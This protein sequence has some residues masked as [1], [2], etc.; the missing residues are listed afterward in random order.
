MNYFDTIDQD[1]ATREQ[2]TNSRH[3]S[4]VFSSQ[5]RQTLATQLSEGPELDVSRAYYK[6]S[7]QQ[8]LWVDEVVQQARE[9]RASKARS[10]NIKRK[11]RLFSRSADLDDPQLVDSPIFRFALQ[12]ALVGSVA[13]YL[14]FVPILTTVDFWWNPNSNLFDPKGEPELLTQLCHRDWADNTLVK[15]F[16]HC[17]PI[18]QEQGAI[19]LLSPESSRE[20]ADKFGYR[21]A[22]RLNTAG[23]LAETNG[24]YLSDQEMQQ[25]GANLEQM[26]TLA[27]DS[28]QVYL[29]DTARCFHRGGRNH[30]TSERLLA[31]LMYLRPG[32]LKIATKHEESP[33]F[34]HLIKADHDLLSRLVL[35]GTD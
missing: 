29:A 6:A 10:N 8:F 7:D 13:R 14:G 20:V 9:L 30:S 24:I 33:P 35:G 3:R 15:V 5:L 23:G 26:Y 2:A 28:G 27:G 12:P 16:V 19:Q 18:Q 22:N 31:V 1:Y 34:A 4:N 25:R 11:N 32:A 17:S 21:Y